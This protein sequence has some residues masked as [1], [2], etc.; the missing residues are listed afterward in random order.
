MKIP[1]LDLKKFWN[2]NDC[3]LTEIIKEVGS[4]GIYLNGYWTSAFEAEF[5][6]FC[7]SDYCVS[8]HSGLDAIKISLQALG[9]GAGDKVLVSSHTYI[10][11][12]LAIKEVGATPVPIDSC[13]SSLNMSVG[14]LLEAL[15]E[16]IKAVITVNMYGNPMDLRELY[17]LL[18]AR[19]IYLIQDQAQSHGATINGEN[20]CLHSDISTFSFYPG[21]NLGALA[22][23]GA[24]VTNLG[25]V[26]EVCR[27]IANY[28][29]SEK[30][31]HDINGCN[32]RLGDLQAAL[33][34]YKLEHDYPRSLSHRKWQADLY[35]SRLKN[36][37]LEIPKKLEFSNSVFHLF[38]VLVDKNLR[39]SFI[40]YLASVGI[41]TIVHYPTP[42]HKQGCFAG[43]VPPYSLD[44]TEDICNRTL[45]LPIGPHLNVKQVEYVC[46]RVNSFKA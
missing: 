37:N 7:M 20:V 46:E 4:S 3:Q 28:G 19:G 45:S 36:I 9:V 17:S 44:I 42:P 41:E 1:F 40:K 30:Y 43:F 10:A 21:K 35:F 14:K 33:L 15:D 27:K 34:Q 26:A 29:Q 8:V 5:A 31:K 2:E 24:I 18:K 22:D 39:Q 6:K 11:T 38:P 13:S 25:P 23:G 12:F 16:S 32:S